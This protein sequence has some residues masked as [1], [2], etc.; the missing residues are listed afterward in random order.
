[1]HAT[2]T[3]ATAADAAACVTLRGRTREN[4]VSVERLRALGI[5]A[6]SWADDIASGR[7]VG[8]TAHDGERLAGYCFG[9]PRTGEVVVLALL[10]EY[11]R[12]G[13]GRTLLQHVVDDLFAAGHERL[14]LG[15]NPDP[16]VRSHG[17]YR[18]LGWRGSGELDAHG[19]EVLWLRRTHGGAP[20][21]S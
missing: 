12:R 10:P 1:M 19:D 17:F 6:E 14:F 11:E 5:T 2:I 15:C 8:W 18:H 13:L 21:A 3:R 4:A 7:V 9:A 20:A 16:R